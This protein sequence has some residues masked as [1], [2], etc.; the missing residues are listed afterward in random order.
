MQEEVYPLLFHSSFDL[1]SA[2]KSRANLYRLKSGG[3][4]R[5]LEGAFALLLVDLFDVGLPR[6]G[7]AVVIVD[8]E[9]SHLASDLNSLL[10]LSTM[11]TCTHASLWETRKLMLQLLRLV[12]LIGCNFGSFRL[13]CEQKFK[14]PYAPI[15]LSTA[16]NS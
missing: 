3:H 1:G 10:N 7:L 12:S 13:A 16:E 2:L 5:L 11:T 14:K 15:N 8:L 6:I 4:F 9:R